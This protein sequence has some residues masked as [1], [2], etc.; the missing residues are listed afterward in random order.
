MRSETVGR[1]KERESLA[2]FFGR[3]SGAPSALVLEGEAGIGKSTLWLEGLD[4]ARA[5]G[6]RVLSTRP[7]EAEQA[8][9]HAGLGDL[10]EDVLEEALPELATPRR[11]ALEVAMLRRDASGAP[12]DPRAVALAVRDVLQSLSSETLVLV[13]VDDVQWLDAS[14]SAALAFALRRLPA[15]QVQLLLARRVG[16]GSQSS[17]LEDSL[18]RTQVWHV[19]VGP[20]SVGALHRLLRDRLGTSF[21]RQTLLRVQEQSGGNPFFALELARALGA[22]LSPLDQ[23]QVPKTLEE[24]LGAR[25]AELPSPTL[26]GLAFVAALGTVSDS[27]LARS[28]IERGDLQPALA[29]H[30]IERSEGAIRF[31]HPLLASVVYRD[32]GELRWRVHATIAQ[33]AEDPLV[34]ARH[35]ALSKAQPDADVAAL[36]DGAASLAVERGAVA[37]SAELL[38]RALRLTPP[39][40]AEARCR[41]TL[42]AARAHLVAGEWTR[43]ETM[44]SDLLSATADGSWR[45]EALLLLSELKVDRVAELLHQALREATSPAL[46]SLIH[47]RLAWATRF[48]P[49]FDHTSAALDLAEAMGDAELRSNARAVQAILDWFAGKAPSPS[50]LAV[51]TYQLPSSLGGERL[52]QEATLATVNTHAVASTRDQARALLDRERAEWLERDE[53]RSAR[54][55]WGL[56][57]V[58]LWA[59]RWELA[60]QHAAHA[61]EISSQYGREVPQ[62]HLPIAVIAVHRGQLTEAR[63]HSE[64]ALVLAEEQFLSYLPQHLGVLGLVALWEGD[65]SVALDRFAEA[66]RQAAALAWGEPS[67]RWWTPDH[68]ELL[69]VGD[70]V[71]DAVDLLDLWSRDATRTDRKRVLADVTR[72]RGLVAAA[73]GDVR[74]ALELLGQSIAEHTA[75]GDPFGTARGQLA[76]GSVG[77]R[78]RQKS[79]ARAATAAALE[80]F[81]SL[82]ATCWAERARTELGRIGGRTRAMG[83]TAAERRV[84]LLVTEGRTNREIAAA[85]FLGERTV[86]SHLTHIYAKLGV[87]SR[88]ELARQFHTG[89]PT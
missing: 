16:D 53:P 13:A 39:D 7:A 12:V 41:R 26:E 25:V 58:E 5:R 85:L 19:A 89:A 44:A 27:M 4:L 40:A 76:L 82:G 59:G 29:V 14:S 32:L 15:S 70:R 9:V 30:V 83:L 35:L 66:D 28:G 81:E 54:A 67:L 47:C 75:A 8:L 17:R 63:H 2:E 43:A 3:T 60:A 49:G 55:S 78:A 72:C 33:L 31:T 68:V 51:L 24:L 38:E 42:A 61:H 77:R 37:A 46:Q 34:R 50:D 74:V 36:L 87:R 79:P 18:P 62:D 84:A 22:D 64:R 69:L 86:A 20:L 6:I 21:A 80:G 48:E 71:D 88:T 73:R 52:V 1:D 23:F 65:A 11:S 56:A 45:A 57:W 10:L